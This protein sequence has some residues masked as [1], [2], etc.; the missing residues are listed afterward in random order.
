MCVCMCQRADV[1]VHWCSPL[2]PQLLAGAACCLPHPGSQVSPLV[3]HKL[4]RQLKL[5]LQESLEQRGKSPPDRTY[6]VMVSANVTLPAGGSWASNHTTTVA[7]PLQLIGQDANTYVDFGYTVAQISLPEEAAAGWLSFSQ[8]TLR[9]LPQ[10]IS[11]SM[12][13]G[14][15][16]LQQVP[17]VTPESSSSSSRG[18][19]GPSALRRRLHRRLLQ[20]ADSN[21]A[22]PP[23]EY[24]VL[25]WSI[26]R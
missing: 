8:M 13:A 22:V 1:A 20:A 21:S 10:R 25:L 5:H 19:I 6:V 24:T 4:T 2:V 3:A 14:G 12:R 11:G 18:G 9:G 17:S 23:T 7:A 26:G 16:R 15:R